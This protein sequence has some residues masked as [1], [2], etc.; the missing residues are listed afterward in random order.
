MTNMNEKEL[1]K[2]ACFMYGIYVGIMIT[3]LIVG[4]FLQ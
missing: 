4:L 2:E 1:S 3:L